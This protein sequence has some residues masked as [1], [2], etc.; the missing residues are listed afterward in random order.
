MAG[1][2]IFVNDNGI[3]KSVAAPYV[4]TSAGY[5]SGIR[6][7]WNK[8]NGAWKQF[9]PPNVFANIIVVG[10]GG[11]GGVGYGWEG[12]GGGGAG[13]IVTRNNVELTVSRL[14][15]VSVG[16]GGGA[17]ASGQDS[18]FGLTDRPQVLT[19]PDRPV[20]A[21]TYGVYPGWLNTYGV[22]FDTSF[23]SGGGSVNYT[24]KITKAGQYTVVCGADNAIQ[25]S[26][27]GT[28]VA[29]N[30]NWGTTDSGTIQLPAGLA[31]IT[32]AAQNWGGPAL[33][34]AT[35]TDFLGNQIWNTRQTAPVITGNPLL[36]IGGGNGGWGS[37]NQ[38]VGN[39]GSGGGGCGYVSTHS[40]GS[41]VSGQGNSGGTGIWQGYGAAGGGGGGGYTS[42]GNQSNGNAGGDGGTGLT[43]TQGGLTFQLAGG[44]AGGYGNQGGSGTGPGGNANCG[45]GTGNGGNGQDGTGGGGGGSM[46]SAYSNAG[47]GGSGTV[48]VQYQ[49]FSAFFTG[50]EVSVNDGWVTHRFSTPGNWSLTA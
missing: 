49:A 33:F 14:Y 27:N 28:P 12:G 34:A 30:A 48:I 20:Y 36:A 35:L 37:P 4:N 24:V 46:H 13:G 15:Y 17:N 32:C 6:A 39:G 11:G 19:T 43:M 29:S 9:W 38:T 18:Y 41:G 8:Q 25:V 2:G 23:N 26:I 42:P 7:G 21:G 50:G 5:A 44:G 31:T 16:A 1:R 3:W 10:G 47:T 40:G 22:W 45:G